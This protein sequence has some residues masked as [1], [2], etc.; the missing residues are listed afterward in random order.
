MTIIPDSDI[1][2]VT[3]DGIASWVRLQQKR[4]I[5]CT[6]R[7]RSSSGAI[8]LW[9]KHPG[10]GVTIT[11]RSI[12]PDVVVE[13]I[14]STTIRDGV[15]ERLVN[16]LPIADAPAWLVELVR[17]SNRA[18]ASSVAT[19]TIRPLTNANRRLRRDKTA[20]RGG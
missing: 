1:F 5:P 18:L 9:F 12:A 8:S 4:P 11:S 3:A 17:A 13:V 7:T 15:G 20:R 14:A 19:A 16:D 10:N 2:V 6:R